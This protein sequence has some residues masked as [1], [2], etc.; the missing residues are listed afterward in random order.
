MCNL[1]TPPLTKRALKC[2]NKGSAESKAAETASHHVRI[3]RF[4][5]QIVPSRVIYSPPLKC[6]GNSGSNFASLLLIKEK[7]KIT[8]RQL[9]KLARRHYS[10]EV[11]C[12]DTRRRFFLKKKSS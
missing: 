9:H 8:C 10:E 1:R 6:F 2:V 7:K 11:S 4:H 5:L 12:D 3:V